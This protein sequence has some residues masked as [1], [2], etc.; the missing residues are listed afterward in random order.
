MVLILKVRNWGGLFL[1]HWLTRNNQS[2]SRKKEVSVTQPAEKKNP[3]KLGLSQ[4]R[5]LWLKTGKGRL[6]LEY[7]SRTVF[8][9]EDKNSWIYYLRI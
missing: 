8:D 3:L 1:A 9:S 5:K 2:Q 4:L 7:H 6:C